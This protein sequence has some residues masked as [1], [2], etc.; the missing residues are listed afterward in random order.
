MTTYNG[1]PLNQH[2][3][4][5]VASTSNQTPIQ[6]LK[7]NNMNN[8]PVN[9]TSNYQVQGGVTSPSM[10]SGRQVSINQQGVIGK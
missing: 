2:N 10:V 6:V 7:T 1:Q 3:Q 9:T 4:H 8:I 5:Y